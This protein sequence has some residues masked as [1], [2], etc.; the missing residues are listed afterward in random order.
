MR[1]VRFSE[2]GPRTWGA[3]LTWKHDGFGRIDFRLGRGGGIGFLH[4]FIQ[5]GANARADIILR[6]NVA[7]LLHRPANS[8]V[9]H[10]AERHRLDALD[11]LKRFFG[12]LLYTSDA[13]DD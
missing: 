7:A 5:S 4:G 6:H 1:R 2:R 10:A 8:Q 13:A 3:L 9:E 11:E 12:C